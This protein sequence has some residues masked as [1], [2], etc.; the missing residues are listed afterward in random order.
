MANRRP[1]N[2][3]V[4]EDDEGWGG[5]AKWVP[6]SQRAAGGSEGGQQTMKELES[7]ALQKNSALT[8]AT[9]NLR[10]ITENTKGVAAQTLVTLNEQGEQINRIHE[11]AVMMDQEMEKSEKLLGKLGGMFSFGWKPKKDKKI[12]GP[13]YAANAKDGASGDAASREA[14]GLG[15]KGPKAGAAPPKATEGMNAMEQIQMEQKF[16]DQ[17]LDD[18]SDGLDALKNMANM[19][20][21]EMGRQDKALDDLTGDVSSMNSR[22]K[23]ANKRATNI[24]GKK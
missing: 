10:R 7:E 16:Q 22:V 11:K 21:S 19:M 23:Q 6:P 18:V 4:D 13:K 12:A 5:G 9:L 3:V 15:G 8:D 17:V 14:L 2:P 20:G 1:S 24:L